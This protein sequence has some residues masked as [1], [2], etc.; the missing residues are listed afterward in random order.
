MTLKAE[1]IFTADAAPI[2]AAAQ[3][4]KNDLGTVSTEARASSS[5]LE[6][7]ADALDKV[8][9]SARRVTT[10]ETAAKAAIGS[11]GKNP[12]AAGRSAANQNFQATNV[13][14]QLQ[15]IFSTAALGSSPL[16]VALQQ[17]P[18]IASALGQGGA[19]GAVST[20]ATAFTSLVNPVSLVTIGLTAAGAAA[21]QYFT[22][23]LTEGEKADETLRRQEQ[24]IREVAERW[25][26][27]LPA[28]KAYAE[29]QQ[30]IADGEKIREASA[31]AA[32]AQWKKV[33]DAASGLNVDFAESLGL[34]QDFGADT[35][36]ISKLQKS[37]GD[38]SDD[39]ETGNAK[40]QEAMSLHQQLSDLYDS[41]G[42][43]ALQ[44]LA[45][46][47]LTL[48]GA[49]KTANEQAGKFSFPNLQDTVTGSTFQADGKTYQ[50]SSFTPEF[51]PRIEHR[52]LKELD[53]LPGE[54][55]ALRKIEQ[56]GRSAAN[57]Y[58]QL[59]K[60][61]SDRVAQMKLEAET[62]GMT[63]AAA[64]ALRFQLDLTSKAEENLQKAEGTGHTLSAKT[65]AM[66]N[67]KV[68]KF[69][70]YAEAAGKARLEADLLFD[71]EQLGRSGFDRQIASQLKSAG[72]PVDFDSYEAGLIR[73]NLQLSYARDLTGDFASTLSNSLEQG[74]GVWQSFGDA[75]VSSLKK[76]SDTLINDVLNSL[77]QVN[78]AAGGGGGLLSGILG[79]FGGGSSGG[80]AFNWA[81]SGDFDFDS[82]GYTG[83]GGVKEPRGIVHAGEVVWS[84]RDVARAGGVGV[85]EAM[86]LGHRGYDA[87]GVVSLSPVR[88]P[89]TRGSASGSAPSGNM[90]MN[91]KV[92]VTGVGDKELISRIQRGTEEQLR[93]GFDQ[94]S[95]QVLPGRVNEI[96]NDPYS[97]G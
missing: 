27:S 86:R 31:A 58:D 53:Y 56:A 94:F 66:I 11:A 87:G 67:E 6:K 54:E 93:N 88:F 2:K 43:P 42:I 68:A 16:T 28:L 37:Y 82:G 44:R 65:V 81:S 47:Y 91:M 15:D 7:H 18:Q 83:A 74:K 3:S 61:A 62:A 38:L 5:A 1:L 46:K 95:R 84:Q 92:E 49:I 14:Y 57:S 63:G 30:R 71:R 76:I 70:E 19:A 23:V 85:V 52:P 78:G 12:F 32:D 21:I 26:E 79:L 9:S 34:L 75:A 80:S 90:T 69:K 36:S 96:Q 29:F 24:V 22:G 25:G 48:A 41:T 72:L 8:A 40:G 97:V 59:V 77:F 33:R 17:G 89:A 50:T 13:A 51:G 10:E 73:T 39:I 60:S 20:L 4:I 64:D 45:E 35:S 55:A